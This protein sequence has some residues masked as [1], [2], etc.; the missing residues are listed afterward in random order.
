M[1]LWRQKKPVARERRHEPPGASAGQLIWLV[2]AILL[3]GAPHLLHVH[4]WVPVVVVTVLLWRVTA[5]LKRSS[6]PSVWIRVPLTLLGFAGVLF[7]YRQITGLGAGSALLLIMASMKLLETRGH[8]DR[9]IVIFICYFLLFSA[10]LREQAIWSAAYLVIGILV[11]TTTLF[12]I[13][14]IGPVMPAPRAMAYTTRLVLQSLPIALLLFLLF[15][16][17]PGPFWS[18]PNGGDQ[19]FTGLSGELNPGDI[20]ELALSDKVAFRVRFDTVPPKT[21]AL[22]W[23]GPVMNEFDGRKW[24]QRPVGRSNTTNQINMDRTA[25]GYEVTLEPHGQRWLLALETPFTWDAY[26][27]HLSTAGQLLHK[28]PIDRRMSYRGTSIL[29]DSRVQNANAITLDWDRALPN[30]GNPRSIAFARQLRDTVAS[31]AQY[32]QELL[33]YFAVEP[34][35]YTLRPP[36]L[37]DDPVDEFLFDTRRGFCGHFASAFT[38]LARAGG[39]PARVVTGY[40][41][42]ERNP[43]GNYWI[44]RQSD[45]HAWAEIWLDG[46]WVRYDPTAMVAPDRIEY[47]FDAAMDRRNETSGNPLTDSQLLVRIAMSWDALNA[48]WNRWVLS[49]GPQTQA[50]MMSL[51]GISH[52]SIEHLVIVMAVSITG[53]LIIIGVVQR[54]RMRPRLDDLLVAYESLCRR[55]GKVVR[56]RQPSEGPHEYLAVLC[57]QRPDLSTELRALFELYIQ[58]RYDG[59][60][61]N[62]QQLRHQ[63]LSAVQAFRPTGLSAA[64]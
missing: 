49:F 58:L 32:L 6:L 36:S 43:L 44:V 38:L 56:C 26:D 34:F 48:G 46:R 35:Y 23:R 54:Y 28:T 55:T 21:S 14:R 29:G 10:F 5:A 42:A 61:D 12:Q 64:G 4:P 30:S 50:T 62:K 16:R 3:T 41:G 19:A 57:E 1:M 52:P 17:I 9:A 59:I 13:A 15:P 20:S 18:I 11:T 39:I 27:A 8:R 33:K 40:Q 45:A 60:D 31:D 22:Y 47:G 7:S 2:A 53:L 24:L 25:I 63:F 37:G 51:I